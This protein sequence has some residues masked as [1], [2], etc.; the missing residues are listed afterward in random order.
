M[1]LQVL[2]KLQDRPSRTHKDSRRL[3]KIIAQ[4]VSKPTSALQIGSRAGASPPRPLLGG[5]R[6]GDKRN[7]RAASSSEI[8]RFQ[9]QRS[10]ARRKKHPPSSSSSLSPLEKRAGASRCAGP[11]PPV[12]AQRRPSSC[13]ERAGRQELRPARED[14][15]GTQPR[16]RKGVSFRSLDTA[17]RAGRRRKGAGEEPKRGGG[18]AA[19]APACVRQVLRATRQSSGKAGKRRL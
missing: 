10:P 14:A 19:A 6:P 18:G 16:A 1:L 12:R 8:P 7:Q 13:L 11:T 15:R 5:D 3:E 4:G 2:L 9:R 17:V